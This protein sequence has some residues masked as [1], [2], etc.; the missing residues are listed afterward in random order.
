M[1]RWIQKHPLTIAIALSISLH[2]LVVTFFGVSRGW[3]FFDMTTAIPPP[4]ETPILIDFIESPEQSSQPEPSKEPKQIIESPA[5]L[6]QA[7]PPKEANHISDKNVSARNPFALQNL[8]IG[9]A[10][11]PGVSPHGAYAAGTNRPSHTDQPTASQPK[12]DDDSAG[13]ELGPIAAPEFRREL[14]LDGNTNDTNRQPAP[15]TEGVLLKNHDTRA[16]ELGS[17]AINTYAWNYAPYL[18]WLKKRI[19]QNIYPPPAFTYLGMISGQT[20]L[21][22]RIYPDGR[23]EGL[24]VLQ[25]AGHKSLMETSTRAV[26]L[27]V[28]LRPLPADFPEPYLEVT[29]LFE[30]LVQRR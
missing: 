8:P 6:S 22:F 21:R 3:K 23:L 14:L 4:N 30:Y 24:R 2:V 20:Q 1:K 10:Y 19:E 16:P 28:P 15:A 27:S 11:S 18:L 12:R 7:E 9:E 5:E 25:S 26:E 17:F 13:D 29:A